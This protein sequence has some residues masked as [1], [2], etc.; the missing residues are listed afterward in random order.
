[1]YSLFGIFVL[2]NG[3]LFIS[4]RKTVTY[5]VLHAY[6][7]E[8]PPPTLSSSLCFALYFCCSLYLM[9]KVESCFPFD[10]IAWM[11]LEDSYIWKVFKGF[12]KSSSIQ[13]K[14]HMILFNFLS[15]F[16]AVRN[17]VLCFRTWQKCYALLNSHPTMK[18]QTLWK[19]T[20]KYLFT[21]V[22]VVIATEIDGIS[23][24]NEE[25]FDWPP[26]RWLWGIRS[27][28]SFY[29]FFIIFFLFVTNCQV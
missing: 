27:W 18:G 17:V 13:F 2:I 15:E 10:G 4:N 23:K 6:T 22:S 3:T 29:K 8:N 24:L 9:F 14:L 1:M 11:F 26:Y 28:I 7:T 21:F 20:H 5:Y 16:E 19:I 12:F 25:N